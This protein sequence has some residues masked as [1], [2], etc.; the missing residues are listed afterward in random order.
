MSSSS[1]SEAPTRRAGLG[2][3]PQRPA[4][5]TSANQRQ[6]R[7][8]SQSESH[9]QST[10]AYLRAVIRGEGAVKKRP[11][12]SRQNTVADSSDDGST[13]DSSEG[14]GG[15]GLPSSFG[16]RRRRKRPRVREAEAEEEQ[17][18]GAWEAH[19]KGVG[20]RLLEK[21]GFTGRLGLREDG[22]SRP[23]ASKLRP[24]RVGIGGGDFEERDLDDVAED[25]MRER[26]GRTAAVGGEERNKGE[27]RRWEKRGGGVRQGGGRK[28]GLQLVDL[29]IG[30]KASVGDDD[31]GDGR[32]VSVVDDLLQGAQA[33][34]K[35]GPLDVPEALFNLRVLVDDTATDLASAERQRTTEDLLRTG[36]GAE[37][38]RLAES[39]E[40]AEKDLIAAE[41]LQMAL[42][43]FLSATSGE[44]LSESQESSPGRVAPLDVSGDSKTTVCFAVALPGFCNDEHVQR[45]LSARPHDPFGIRDTVSALVQAHVTP[46]ASRFIARASGKEN[47]VGSV[48]GDEDLEKLKT[49]LLATQAV[50]GSRNNSE[51]YTRLCCRVLVNPLRRVVGTRWDPRKPNFLADFLDG[52][53]RALPSP[54]IAIFLET[55]LVPRLLREVEEWSWSRSRDARSPLHVWIFPWL[56]VFGKRALASVFGAVREKLSATLR[57]WSSQALVSRR[58]Q[59]ESKIPCARADDHTAIVGLLKPWLDVLSRRKLHSSLVRYVAPVLQKR[60]STGIESCSDRYRPG[61]MELAASVHSFSPASEI[62]I[63]CS[64][65]GCTESARILLQAMF[66]PLACLLQSYLFSVDVDDLE[67]IKVV[68]ASSAGWY[69]I[70]R[71]AV[72]AELL[73]HVRPG[74][75]VFLFLIHASSQVSDP[76]QRALLRDG[77]ISTLF[78]SGGY[79]VAEKKTNCASVKIAKARSLPLKT[80][81]SQGMR[82]SLKDVVQAEAA[83]QGLVFHYDGRD[84]RDGQPIYAFGQTNVVL[85]GARKLILADC[86]KSGSTLEGRLRP[87]DMD[88]LVQLGLGRLSD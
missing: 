76:I 7:T 34:A 74:L 54:L 49:C 38:R 66:M 21:M 45:E 4:H 59:P 81:P 43:R 27:K 77:E 1:S 55:S 61:S 69:H 8:K 24:G 6:R 11:G 72:P 65:L 39:L 86:G 52:V 44:Q 75:A 88:L 62:G 50:L 3:A 14:G 82:A 32:V 10:A 46:L 35:E 85:D 41:A 64:V 70:C 19:T 79:I 36:V 87:V 25:K 68:A 40:V 57:A 56:P 17:Q 26:E 60:I 58:P 47:G 84:T 73:V 30:K 29:E 9:N 18:P 23:I 80:Q 71:E 22:I 51:L 67:K 5:P 2:G 12:R 16:A 42:T 48:A 78:A 28:V 20:T 83:R 53:R 15:D 37:R 63:W 33:E 31:N 13:S